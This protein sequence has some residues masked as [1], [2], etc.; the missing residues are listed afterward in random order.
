MEKSNFQIAFHIEQRTN[1]N[2]LSLCAIVLTNA[3]V[4]RID[5][6]AYFRMHFLARTLYQWLAYSQ[7]ILAK[8]GLYKEN[9]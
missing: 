8:K 6:Y 4:I 3:K 7:Y 1:L 5:V 9:I 2:L